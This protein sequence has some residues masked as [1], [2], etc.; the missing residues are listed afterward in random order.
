MNSRFLGGWIVGLWAAMLPLVLCADSAQPK[1]A[2]ESKPTAE[3]EAAAPT[4]PATAS[5]ATPAVDA[6]PAADEPAPT[7]PSEEPDAGQSAAGHPPKSGIEHGSA[8]GGGG[9]G[10]AAGDHGG[11]GH[12]DPTDLSHANATEW[13]ER[14]E[15]WRYDLALCTLAVFL[16]L[17]A[18]LT[19]FAWGPISEGLTKREQSIAAMI[20]EAERNRKEA[21][22][23]FEKYKAMLAS[24]AAEAQEI[25][26]QSRKDAEAVAERIRAEAATAATR[27]K[28][29][30][31][32]E[33][34]AAKNTALQQVAQRGADMAVML[35]GRIV[36]RELKSVDHA[37]L[38]QEALEQFPSK[39]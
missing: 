25:I 23:E 35:A 31:V 36:H 9:H 38:I 37:S 11:H 17:M 7:V 5:E 19:K 15:E 24:A 1:P 20:E 30:A 6:T 39:N 22:A 32:A 13:L 12:R 8:A 27:Q 2:G 10:A 4:K 26:A 29:R 21:A 16:L 14:P 3:V 28:D 34:V 33:I 18:I